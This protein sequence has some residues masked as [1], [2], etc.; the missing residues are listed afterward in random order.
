VGTQFRFNLYDAAGRKV[1]QQYFTG[2]QFELQRPDIAAGA[3]F[4]EVTGSGYQI[5]SGQVVLQ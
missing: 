2:D 1:F 4:Y 3:Y 5:G